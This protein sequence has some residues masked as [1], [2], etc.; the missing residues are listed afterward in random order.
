VSVPRQQITEKR[1]FFRFVSHEYG[2]HHLPISRQG[3][4]LQFNLV[5]FHLYPPVTRKRQL[6]FM[7]DE[8]LLAQEFPIFK[9]P[10]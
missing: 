2:D 6:R 7:L 9:F 3:D 10:V 5:L 8:S 1:C 4:D